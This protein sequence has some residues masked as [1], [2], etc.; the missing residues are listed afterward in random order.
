MISPC[1]ALLNLK[2]NFRMADW[3]QVLASNDVNVNI[4]YDFFW[5]VYNNLFEIN[6]PLKRKSSTKT[7]IQ[8]TNL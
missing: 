1:P 8:K 4:A 6:F 7:L 3:H 2:N 5:S